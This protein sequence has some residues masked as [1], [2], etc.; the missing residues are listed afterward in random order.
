MNLAFHIIAPSGRSLFPYESE[1][2]ALTRPA[3]AA[4][5]CAFNMFGGGSSKS[6][7]TSND[8]RIVAQ[9]EARV[10]ASGANLTESGAISVASGGKFLEGIDLGGSNQSSVSITTADP[11]VLTNALNKVTE[12]GAQ[13]G[14]SLGDFAAQTSLAQADQLS[15]LLG[16]LGDLGQTTELEGKR[17]RVILYIVLGLLAVV[18]FIFYRQRK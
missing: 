6:A 11:E 15:T 8:N 18:G 7:T 14:G 17:D 1:G 13:F 4:A 5:A 9:D 2:P 10:L 12:L 3:I 16:A